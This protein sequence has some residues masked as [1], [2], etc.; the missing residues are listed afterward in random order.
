MMQSLLRKE[1]DPGKHRRGSGSGSVD[2]T[3]VMWN[4]VYNKQLTERHLQR[5]TKTLEFI[6]DRVEQSGEETLT[7]P[8]TRRTADKAG[9][10]LLADY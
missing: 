10:L 9:R 7:D 4:L 8:S 5:L 3:L 2:K 1:M 6:E